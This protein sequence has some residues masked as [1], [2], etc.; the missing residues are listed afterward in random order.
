MKPL[1]APAHLF[2]NAALVVVTVLR[3]LVHLQGACMRER[4]A[5]DVRV[6]PLHTWI[7]VGTISAAGLAGREWLGT[8]S[9][10]A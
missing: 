3:G 7:R 2:Q 6:A 8:S 10:A 1:P 9:K 4:M 5:N